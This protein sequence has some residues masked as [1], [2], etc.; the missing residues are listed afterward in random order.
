[1]FNKCSISR[2]GPA[3]PLD[4]SELDRTLLRRAPLTSVVFQV[5]FNRSQ[6][7]ADAATARALFER[8]GG[9]PGPFPIL[10]Q[11]AETG[12]NLTLSGIQQPVVQQGGVTSGWRIADNGK[13]TAISLLP[14]SV[15]VETATY[16]G[17]DESF[18]DL[19]REVLE[20]VSELV[21]PV[22]EER[23]GLRYINQIID[24]EV[25]DPLEWQ[26]WIAGSFLGLAADAELSPMTSFIRQ[27]AL[28][29][30]DAEV[31]CNLN[32]GFA[33]DPERSGALTFL[34]DSDVYREG[35][36]PFELDAIRDAGTTFNAYA[37]RLFQLGTS[38]D[39]R[40]RLVG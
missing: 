26:T 17:W 11:I 34:L 23:L 1:M 36:R 24:P 22:F 5:R 9:S 18:A 6:I 37:L 21:E 38:G 25:T 32:V 20:A 29:Q 15:S 8:F 4:L 28:L 10:E 40:A 30:L 2:R 19:V 27:Q 7:A 3:L 35:M 13:V 16:A 14:T 31:R 39:L 33:P 12:I